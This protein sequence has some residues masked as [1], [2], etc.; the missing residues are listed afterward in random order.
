MLPGSA[1][2][3]CLTLDMWLKQCPSVS[4]SIQWVLRVTEKVES[5]YVKS[6]ERCLAHSKYSRNFD[7]LENKMCKCLHE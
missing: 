6:L 1:T 4:C 3:G 2:S 5:V 7:P